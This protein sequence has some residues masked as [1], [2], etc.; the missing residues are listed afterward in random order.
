[1]LNGNLI[2]AMS[3]IAVMSLWSGLSLAQDKSS[4][5]A[6]APDETA[7]EES[8]PKQAF[9]PPPGFRSKKRGGVLVYCIKDRS[10]G[11][12][13][14]SEKCYDEQGVKDYLLARDEN[15]RDIDQRR[16]ICT[17]CSSN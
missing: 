4:D 13:F 14:Q 6:K 8:T 2:R 1:M 7:T 5:D 16:S 10:L 15:K 3:L 12:R 17:A 9:K 11:S